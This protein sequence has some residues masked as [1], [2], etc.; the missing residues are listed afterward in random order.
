[1]PQSFVRTAAVVL[2]AAS[3]ACASSATANAAGSAGLVVRIYDTTGT[4]S[5]IRS[6]AIATASAIVADAGI[7]VEWRDCTTTSGE[8]RCQRTPGSRDLI[9]R[10]IP[11]VA[12]GT[13]FRGSALQLR[14][15]P[16]EMSLPLGVAVI[17]PVTLAGEMAT[18]FHQ[19]VRSVARRSGVNDAELLGRAFA[20]EVGHLLLRVRAHSP[21]GLMR[22]VWSIQELTRNRREDWL[23]APADRQRL[24]LNA[25]SEW[26]TSRIT[27]QR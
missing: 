6:A 11:A 19:Q 16:G 27:S 17:N 4:A 8:A 25:A 1:M 18:V 3:M 14:M 9:V 20:H 24:Q 22:G 15:A 5:D 12:P 7:S 23:F 10:I 21:A 26:Q 13:I 2:L